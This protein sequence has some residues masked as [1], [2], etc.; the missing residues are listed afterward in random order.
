MGKNIIITGA[1]DGIGAAAARQLVG[2]GHTVVIVGRSAEKTRAVAEELGSDYFVADY[3][4]LADVRALAADLTA[5]YPRIDVLAN[6][7]G[8]MFGDREPTVDGFE[9]TLQV[10]HLA[11]FLLTNLLMPTLVHSGARVIQ[12]SSDAARIS[13]KLNLSDLANDTKY[14]AMKAYGDAKLENILFTTELHERYFDRGLTATAFHPG[15]V[16][17]NFASGSASALARF[18]Y[19]GPARR[20]MT[21]PESAAAQL[22]WLATAPTEDLTSGGYYE[23]R[24]LAKK[25]HPQIRD[26][27]LARSLWTLSS[28]LVGLPVSA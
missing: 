28:E 23:K 13:G 22:V 8:G 18:V 24:K 16:S 25:V 15:T 14:S 26:R 9:K 12:T 7:A 6:N 17:S 19:N 1:S 10:N 20:L 4:R 5:A 3:S 11:P 27:Q 2:A 21:T